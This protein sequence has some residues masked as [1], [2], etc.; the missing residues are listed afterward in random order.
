MRGT[1]PGKARGR[2]N[3][4]TVERW[5]GGTVEWWNGNEDTQTTA[6]NTRRDAETTEGPLHVQKR[7]Q[8]RTPSDY[9]NGSFAA[10]RSGNGCE[11]KTKAVRQRRVRNATKGWQA[12]L[13]RLCRES[14]QTERQMDHA[15]SVA[16]PFRSLRSLTVARRVL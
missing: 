6:D 12:S 5:N 14:I 11:R 10:N 4:G 15:L 7:R 13:P 3:G 9:S 2:W 1:D 8:V 16:I